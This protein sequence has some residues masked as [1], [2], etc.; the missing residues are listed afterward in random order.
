M[1]NKLNP[2]LRSFSLSASIALSATLA[3]HAGAVT[4]YWTG[5]GTW[6]TTN[7]NWA[8]TS[9]GTYN[10]VWPNSTADIA[11]F[12]GTAG[13]VSV[14]SN[15]NV[16]NL[17]FN[18][19]GNSLTGSSVI[20]TGPS[21]ISVNLAASVTASIGN[22]ITFTSSGTNTSFNLNGLDQTTNTL[23][24][25]G[26]IK[27]TTAN[28]SG[29]NGLKVSVGTGGLIQSSNSTFL[30]ANSSGSGALG[31]TLVL[32]G[33]SFS[34]SNPSG[35]TNFIIGHTGSNSST[36]TIKN[37]GIFSFAN[38]ANTGGV[39]FGSG[40]SAPATQLTG[41]LNLDGGTLETS[42]IYMG[43]SFTGGATYNATVNFNGGTLKAIQNN[44][45]FLTGLVGTGAIVKAGGAVIDSNTFNV[46]IGQALLH[47]S[48]LGSTA[49][50]GLEKKGGGTLTLNANN[51]YTGNT[52]VNNGTLAISSLGGLKFVI[53]ATGVNNQIT[54]TGAGS[55]SLDGLF[56]FD[57]ANASTAVNASWNIVD[58]ANLTESYGSNFSIFGFTP[59]GG[60][61]L[62]NGSANGASYRFS[63][64]SGVLTVIP[65]P[66]A[67]ILGGMGLVALLRRRRA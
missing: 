51:T 49:D 39:R 29:I 64:S 45:S 56:T 24:L 4:K 25:S 36:L 44:S 1:K 43:G 6:N 18:A 37:G 55:V 17:T 34:M 50:G 65:E 30:G 35:N 32:D 27:N 28:N 63:E 14:G 57:L 10:T 53:G 19:S 47:D 26:T 54:G 52:L 40:S 48:A 22:G 3:Q 58:V 7:T 62:W 16:A 67:A 33:G 2:S 38:S 12:E 21:A 15:V 59:D 66:S 8:T 9:G 5:T 13:A 41:T 46:T 11:I 42:K 60:G 23:N 61:D 31:A 20:L